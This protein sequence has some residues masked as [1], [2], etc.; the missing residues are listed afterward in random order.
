MAKLTE[1]DEEAVD[2]RDLVAALLPRGPL[3][4]LDNPGV[5]GVASGLGIEGVRFHNRAVDL[6]REAVPGTA[7]ETLDEWEKVFGL[8]LPGFV[9]STLSERQA[10]L[11][12]RVAARGGQDPHYYIELARRVLGDPEADVQVVEWPYGKPFRV[13][14]SAVGDPLNGAGAMFYWRLVLPAGSTSAQ[15]ETVEALLALYKPGHTI[16]EVTV[17]V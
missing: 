10:A 14:L 16:V 7:V 12:G 3:W 2:Y 6:M 11:S 4:S 17:G 9:P 8:P 5:R 15:V 1:L 13:S